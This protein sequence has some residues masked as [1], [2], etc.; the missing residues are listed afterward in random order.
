MIIRSEKK[1]IKSSKE[2]IFN[3]LRDFSNFESLMPDEIS[4]WS[5]TKDSCYFEI[6]N[7]ATIELRITELKEPDYQGG[8]ND[9]LR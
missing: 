5:S 1:E 4:N 9:N 7:M 3:F 8:C 2:V 6:K